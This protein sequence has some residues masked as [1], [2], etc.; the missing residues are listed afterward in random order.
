MMR[1]PQCKSDL[2]RQNNVGRGRES[3]ASSYTMPNRLS[4]TFVLLL[5]HTIKN[6]NSLR[7]QSGTFGGSSFSCQLQNG[8]RENSETIRNPALYFAAVLSLFSSS[9]FTT[10]TQIAPAVQQISA[11]KS[12]PFAVGTSAAI[13]GL[14]TPAKALPRST[15]PVLL[16]AYFTP[17]H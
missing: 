16:L 13:K 4:L 1:I 9:Q 6:R 2:P 5:L 14:N 7:G 15:S 11:N 8:K 3:P 17:K 10:S 12:L